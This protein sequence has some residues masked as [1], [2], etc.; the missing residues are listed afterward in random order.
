MQFGGRDNLVPNGSFERGV[1]P[2]VPFTGT[3]NLALTKAHKFGKVALLVRPGRE[4][5]AIG[6]ADLHFAA[7]PAP[8]SRYRFS[9]WVR[10]AKGGPR[11]LAGIELAVLE[12]HRS[13]WTQ[14]GAKGRPVTGNWQL[15][16]AS[17]TVPKGN[18]LS[19]RVTVSLNDVSPGSWLAIDGVKAKIVKPGTHPNVGS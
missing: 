15:L 11:A 2:W 14:I 3:R 4:S 12:A 18:P 5:P 1:W 7:K 19:L 17:G 6:A 8:G 16:T 13:T 10:G 9:A